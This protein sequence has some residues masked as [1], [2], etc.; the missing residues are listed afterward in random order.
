VTTITLAENLTLDPLQTEVSQAISI[1]GFNAV[2]VGIRIIAAE[3]GFSPSG[4]F[5][6]VEGSD[7]LENWDQTL[8]QYYAGISSSPSNT[9]LPTS[10][11]TVNLN[12]AYARVKYTNNSTATVVL[13]AT[14]EPQQQ[15]FS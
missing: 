2:R 8:T 10:T 12:Y 6:G 11:P 7:D 3:S 15:Y 9:F 4:M 14:I 5:V 13:S 1:E